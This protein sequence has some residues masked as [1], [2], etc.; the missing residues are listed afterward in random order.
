MKLFYQQLH[1][2]KLS[3]ICISKINLRVSDDSSTCSV[4]LS[5]SLMAIR[6]MIPVISMLLLPSPP[7][8]GRVR[9]I[10]P[11]YKTVSPAAADPLPFSCSSLLDV[12]VVVKLFLSRNSSS[13]FRH[14]CKCVQFLFEKYIFF[15]FGVLWWILLCFF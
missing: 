9:L 3:E 10:H 15:F 6:S 11:P 2:I 7:P 1:L 12:T 4:S 5:L 13:L 8:P 14:E